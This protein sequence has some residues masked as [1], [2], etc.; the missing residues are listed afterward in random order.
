[1]WRWALMLTLGVCRSACAPHELRLQRLG[2]QPPCCR[3]TN[4]HSERHER[5]AHAPDATVAAVH[6]QRSALTRKRSLVQIQYRPPVPSLV[7][8]SFSTWPRRLRNICAR[9]T[10]TRLFVRV[11]WPMRL[12]SPPAGYNDVASTAL[13][14]LAGALRDSP[15]SREQSAVNAWLGR[16][17]RRYSRTLRR[18]PL[19]GPL[20]RR[21]GVAVNGYTYTGRTSRLLARQAEVAGGGLGPHFVVWLSRRR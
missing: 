16:A 15:G 8:C 4:S 9:A 2:R 13:R 17:D 3:P 7:R 6:G 10:R 1:V 20:S 19:V 14:L 12:R 18:L 11:V 21:Y 5:P